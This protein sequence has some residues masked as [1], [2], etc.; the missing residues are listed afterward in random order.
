VIAFAHDVGTY[1]SSCAI[2]IEPSPLEDP[3][4]LGKFLQARSERA[5]QPLGEGDAE[6]HLP[7]SGV[8]RG[9]EAGESSADQALAAFG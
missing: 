8:I 9:Q 2:T 6:R 3:A 5:A 4:L 1:Q 7:L